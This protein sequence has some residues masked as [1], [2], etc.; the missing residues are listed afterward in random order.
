VRDVSGAPHDDALAVRAAALMA[1]AYGAASLE[2]AVT[3]R[4][5]AQPDGLA[6]VEDDDGLV[7]AGG[8]VAYPSGGFGWIGLIATEPGQARRGGAR[9][10]T[11]HLIAGLAR[12]GCAP[13]LDAS[14][15]GAPVYEAMAFVDHGFTTVLRGP[16]R[17][18]A[19]RAQATPLDRLTL[20]HLDELDRYDAPRFGGSRRAVLAWFLAADG[21]HT[22]AT[23]DEGGRLTG[24][25]VADEAR[26]GP[27]VAD[28]AEVAAA[29]V[30]A[31]VSRP[32]LDPLTLSVTPESEHLDL[33]LALGFEVQR[34]LRHM[35]RGID[36]L[37]GRRALV[38]AEASLGEG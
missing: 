16:A 11:D 15:A 22:D 10:V 9:L 8:F 25:L 5:V 33:L 36:A 6:V 27:G 23:R 18:V 34:Q 2:R 35:R 32:R 30:T 38:L 37:P 1:R 21:A 31:A 13:V 14:A 24:Y 4:R 19:A 7:S 28:D 29:L 3:R 26:L 20:E 17:P 12:H